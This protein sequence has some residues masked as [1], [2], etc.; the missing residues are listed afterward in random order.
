MEKAD[1]I[2]GEYKAEWTKAG[3]KAR[4]NT[5]WNVFGEEKEC[6]AFVTNYENFDA[7]V[8]SRAEVEE[9]VGKD[10]LSE[11]QGKLGAISRRIEESESS[12][13]PDLSHSN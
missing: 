6:V 1:E 7:W 8:A 10:K 13:R 12:G 3:I 2:I 5:Y 4:T 9:K 11:L